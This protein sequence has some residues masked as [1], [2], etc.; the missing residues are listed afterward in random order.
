MSFAMTDRSAAHDPARP[1][2]TLASLSLRGKLLLFAAGLILIPGFIFGLMAQQSGSASLQ[3]V[4]GRQLAREARHTA[5]RFATLLETERQALQNLSH[6]QVMREI[7]VADIDKRVSTALTTL[8]RGSAAR[9]DYLVVD[10]D[11]RI[12]AS[13]NP[14]LIGPL[15]AWADTVDGALGGAEGFFGPARIPAY[16][17]E[18]VLLTTP[19]PDP[20]DE[21]SVIGAVVGML[22]WQGLTGVMNNVRE[23]LAQLGLATEVFI[24]DADGKVVGGT[25]AAASTSTILNWA[26]LAGR[27]PLRD[28]DY[29][30]QQRAGL[31]VGRATLAA[32]LPAWRLLI[33]E[34]LT[35]AL[36]PARSLTRRLAVTLAL[37]LAAAL[38]VATVAARRVARPLSELT[39]AIRGLSSGNATLRPV[40]VRTEDEVGSLATAFNRMATDLDRAQR[41]LVE[42]AKF[43]FVG[44]LAGGIAHEVRTSLGVLRSSAQILER[45]LPA[46]AD[47]SSIELAQL[48]RAEVDRLG[49]VVDDLLTLSRPRTLQL[50]E[51]TIAAPVSRA[52]E[53]VEPQAKQRGIAIRLHEADRNLSLRCD[54]E[55]VYRVALNLLVN[56]LQAIDDGGHI[57]VR[58]FNTGDHVGFEVADDGR[59]IPEALREKVFLPFVTAREGGIGLGL[60]FVKRVVHEHGGRISLETQ[61]GAGARFRVELPIAGRKP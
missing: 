32:G 13:S 2:A 7:R 19:V 14:R 58:T 60:T 50:E 52:I 54:A 35:A 26:E 29:V 12:V 61:E 28:P 5:D 25:A 24:V 34:P 48:M 16:G 51:T 1:Q 37:T 39:E 9:L 59:G 47:P 43:A 49:G 31:L 30:V 46:D 42:A 53:F 15:P 17:R 6:Q 41:D 45:S 21:A 36:A 55:L 38:G 27:A 20:D 18:A 23:E 33:V 22:D 44:E 3:R 10:R 40:P 56:A 11:R 4:I 8:R 57:D